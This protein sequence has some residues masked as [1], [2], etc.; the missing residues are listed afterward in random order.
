[1]NEPAPKRS[2]HGNVLIVDDVPT[3][4]SNQA[5]GTGKREF[6]PPKK[7]LQENQDK[8]VGNKLK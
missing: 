5:T 3:N 2:K 7:E 8:K 1:M 4:S 6:K